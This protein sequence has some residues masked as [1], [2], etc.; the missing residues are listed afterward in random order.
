ML[1]CASPSPRPTA[2]AA[3]G[4]QFIQHMMQLPV[5][6]EQQVAKRDA[7]GTKKLRKLLDHVTPQQ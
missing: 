1:S 3:A 4:L 2:A 6:D 5:T 7:F